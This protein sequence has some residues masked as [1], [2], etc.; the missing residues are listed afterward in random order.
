VPALCE[1]LHTSARRVRGWRALLPHIDTAWSQGSAVCSVE[2][3]LDHGEHSAGDCVEEDV[4][5][6]SRADADACA[7]WTLAG[8]HVGGEGG[9]RGGGRGGAWM[10]DRGEEARQRALYIRERERKGR[11]GEKSKKK[12]SVSSEK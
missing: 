7:S 10:R 11:R 12:K 1:A 8:L 6:L 2:T 3:A 9:G 4:G 5:V